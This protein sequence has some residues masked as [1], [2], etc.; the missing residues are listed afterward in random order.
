[1]HV[2]PGASPSRTIT[3]HMVNE[4][5]QSDLALGKSMLFENGIR[6]TIDQTVLVQ[7]VRF[8]FFNL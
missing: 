6:S 8:Y 4:E 5:I 3:M 7:V 2:G 1:M